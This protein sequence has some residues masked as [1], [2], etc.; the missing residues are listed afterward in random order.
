[1]NTGQKFIVGVGIAT[2][3]AASLLVLPALGALFGAMGA[4]VVGW[5]FPTTMHLIAAKFGLT[6]W[7][8]GA[9]CGFFSGYASRAKASPPS[10]D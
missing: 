5:W 3:G 6:V 2:L 7:Q 9:A 8:L 4:T 1:M 10:S